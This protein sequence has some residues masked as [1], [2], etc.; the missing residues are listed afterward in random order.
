MN[1][2]SSYSFQLMLALNSKV[3][4]VAE[5]LKIL[6]SWVTPVCRNGSYLMLCNVAKSCDFIVSHTV[7]DIFLEDQA[8]GMYCCGFFFTF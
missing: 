8:P 5:N 1:C 3:S 4:T 6:A 7:A 2:M